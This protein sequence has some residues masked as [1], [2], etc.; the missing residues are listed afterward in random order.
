MD[1]RIRHFATALIVGFIVIWSGLVYWQVVRAADLGDR[2]DNPR[3][4]EAALR[5]DRGSIVDRNGR[6]LAETEREENGTARRVYSTPSLS[7]IIG[8]S[9]ARFGQSGLERSYN[10]YLTGEAGSGLINELLSGFR[11]VE[12]QGNTL[13]LTIDLELQQAV[14]RA[15]GNRTGAA[16]V[17]D[18]KTGAV[19][20]MASFP[21]FDSNQI[22]EQGDAL[23]QD[24][25]R[26]LLN[27]AAQGLYTP[28]STFKTVTAA[29]ALDTNTVRPTDTFNCRDQFVVSGFG[30]KCENVPGGEGVHDFTRSYALSI[31]AIFAEVAL[32]VGWERLIEYSNRFGFDTDLDFDIDS[33]V[34]RVR[35]AE[36][37]RS[38]VLLASTGFGQGEL[39]ATPL[40][41]A[42]VAQ[43]VANGGVAMHPFLVSEVRGPDGG[44]LERRSPRQLSRVMRADSARSLRQMM[45]TSTTDGF[46]GPAAPPG[47]QVAGKTGTAENADGEPH[48]WY[49]GF[50]PADNPAVAVA[51]VLEHGGAGGT[52]AAPLAREIFQ[53]ALRGQR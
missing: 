32:K 30:I 14:T 24:Q 52:F 3:V 1:A 21:T 37:E 16:V 45:V 53:A 9:S 7:P 17:L 19:L 31:N 47:V 35:S 50:A 33:S 38:G 2:A 51:V 34:S 26:P 43:T 4:T 25:R 27:R 40:Q 42:V 48:A 12:P 49:I 20:A 10:R 8:Y 29:A 23:N 11:L 22:E 39:Q 28:G 36:S 13:A 46:A 15:L 6:L 18:A 5:A 41:M 44:V